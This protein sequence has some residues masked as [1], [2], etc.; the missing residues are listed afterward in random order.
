MEAV[1][2]RVVAA[3]PGPELEIQRL[4]PATEPA[5]PSPTQVHVDGRWVDA[6][7]VWRR[8]LSPGHELEGPAV[9]SE[10]SSTTWVPEGWRLAVDDWGNLHLTTK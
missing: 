2:L 8:E 4:P 1:T 5:T 10:Y 7:C 3:A 6:L 9:V